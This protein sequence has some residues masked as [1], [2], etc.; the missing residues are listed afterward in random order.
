MNTQLLLLAMGI[1]GILLHNFV[2]LDSIN[3]ANNGVI[4]FW[5]YLAIEKFSIIISILVVVG[6]TI[7][8]QEIKQLEFAG[9]WLAL[10]FLAIGYLAQ[11][12]LI[13]VMSKAQNYV[14]NTTK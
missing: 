3:R 2:K 9:K 6:A 13:K 4:D 11:S 12:I 10:G 5:K 14:D 7:G 1:I 8:S